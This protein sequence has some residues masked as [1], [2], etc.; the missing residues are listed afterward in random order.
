MRNRR[1]LILVGMICLAIAAI[2]VVVARGSTGGDPD[3]IAKPVRWA[4]PALEDPTQV[5]LGTGYSETTLAPTEDAVIKLPPEPT[6]GGVTILGGHDIVLIGGQIRIP[7]G[8]ADAAAA[9]R[10]HTGIYIKGA[11]GTVHIEGVLIEGAGDS[12]F[13]GIDV[14]APRATVDIENVRVENVRGTYH[15]V[16]GDVVQPWGGVKRLR[17]DRLSAS[18]NYQ[19]LTLKEDLGPIGSMVV[20]RADLVGT[21]EEPLEKGGVLLWLTPKESCAGFPV[22]LWQVYLEPREGRRQGKTTWPGTKSKVPCRAHAKRGAFV[23]PR[24]PVRGSAHFG[25]PPDGEFVPPG[26][27]GTGYVSGGYATDR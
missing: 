14:A 3:P 20:S 19:G 1:K 16:H 9:N 23:W 11:T 6:E 25:A 7:E 12:Q 17:I 24:L 8:T 4:P 21:T 26:V 13:D 18:S 15:G 27:A 5:Q 10:F 22:R 2:V